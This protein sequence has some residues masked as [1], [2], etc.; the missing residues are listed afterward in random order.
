VPE[1][2]ADVVQLLDIVTFQ[3]QG[4]ADAVQAAIATVHLVIVGT[5]LQHA[6]LSGVR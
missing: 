1:R 5:G 6:A 3:R 4:Q 2:T